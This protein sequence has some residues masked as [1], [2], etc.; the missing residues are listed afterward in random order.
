MWIRVCPLCKAELQKHNLREAI[1]RS[2]GWV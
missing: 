2:C 1:R